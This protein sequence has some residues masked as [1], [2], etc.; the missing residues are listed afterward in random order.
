MPCVLQ[1]NAALEK[2]RSAQVEAGKKVRA[3]EAMEAAP[4][5]RNRLA[6][7]LLEGSPRAANA[8][9]AP[10]RHKATPLELASALLE[11]HEE[12]VKAR[13]VSIIYFCI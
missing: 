5:A 4:F 3:R 7:A 11:S 2:K 8:N 9:P 13:R 12:P 6:G 10:K 1:H